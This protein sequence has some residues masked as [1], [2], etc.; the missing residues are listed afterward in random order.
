MK[1][2]KIILSFI[3]FFLSISSCTRLVSPD[4]KMTFSENLERVW[5]GPDYWAN[6]LQDWRLS[7]GRVECVVS[8]GDRNLF[9]LTYE[10]ANEPKKFEMSVNLGSLEPDSAKLSEGWVGFKIGIRGQFQDY[11]DDAVHG[12]GYPVGITTEGYLFIGNI[13]S[14]T[15]K[16]S[17]LKNLQLVLKAEPSDLSYNLILSVFDRSNKE[18]IQIKRNGINS[19]WLSGGVALVCSNGKLT[20]IAE[21]RPRIDDGNWGF[22]HGTKRGGNV[23]FWFSEW[24]ISGGKIHYYPKRAYGPI[25]FAQYTLSNDLLKLTA[26]LVPVG[27]KE[28]ETVKFQIQADE[29]KWETVSESQI[30]RLARTATFR[31]ENW[32]NSKDTPY[33]IVYPLASAAGKL[34]NYYFYGTVRKE[35]W[36]KEEIVVAAFTGNNDLGFPNNDIIKQ[37]DHLNPDLLFFSGDQIYEGVGGYGVQRAPLKDACLDYLR[38]WYIFGWAYKDLM[39]NRP[40]VCITDDHDVFHGNLWGAGG[41]ATPEGLTGYKAQD[42]GGYKMPP[43]WVNMVQRTQTSHLPDPYDPKPVKQGIGVYFCNM[44]YAGISFAILEDRKFKSPPKVLLPEAQIRNG[45][46]QNRKFNAKIQADVPGAV[47]LGDRQLKFLN[48]WAEDWSKGVWIKVVLS[49]TIFANVATLPREASS[50]SIIPRLKIL[51]SGEYPP[52]DIP[53]SDMDSNGWP[54]SSRNRA[55]REMRKAFAFH[56]A[57]DQ[58]LGST[59]Q[60]GIEDWHDA[61]YAFCVPAVSNIWPRRWFPMT[62]GENRKPGAPKYTGDF[63][64]GFGNKI[65]VLAVSNPV[66]TGRKPSRLYDRATGF[67]IVRFNRKTR[68]ITIECFPRISDSTLTVNGQFPGWPVKINQIDNGFGAAKYHLPEVRAQNMKNPVIQVIDAENNEVIYTIR[69]SGTKFRPPVNKKG[70]YKIR[71]IDTKNGEVKEILEKI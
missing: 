24:T 25:L 68:D 27:E 20:K 50:G 47:L 23:R 39:K 55:L 61:G 60:Y 63:E 58:H 22:R 41:V 31:V 17:S 44:N 43:E 6:P 18:L 42:A 29:G 15:E 11:R 38:K 34:K 69:I 52:D 3:L 67:G 26:Q 9:L 35:P 48:H 16:I 28:R 46:A 71:I 21:K 12:V 62:P 5:I 57:G 59:I 51:K 32:D 36:D 19:D 49:Q 66:F 7:H 33:R 45:W 56:I 8:G 13:D 70:T 30:D 40:T 14:T 37:L 2:L 4:F 54:Q 1:I 64:D 53:V 65:T 10:L